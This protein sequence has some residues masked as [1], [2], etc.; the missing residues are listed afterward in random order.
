M[1]GPDMVLNAAINVRI[2]IA[3]IVGIMVGRT[4]LKRIVL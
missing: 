3:K 4:I 1:S 2:V